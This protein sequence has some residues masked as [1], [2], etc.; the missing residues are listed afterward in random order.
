LNQL[1]SIDFFPDFPCWQGTLLAAFK[2][3]LSGKEILEL[4]REMES[5]DDFPPD[6]EIFEMVLEYFLQKNFTEAIEIVLVEMKEREI[7]VSPALSERLPKRNK[8]S[9]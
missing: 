3:S 1:R 5:L 2:K 6:S 8:T 7:S 9:S 4:L